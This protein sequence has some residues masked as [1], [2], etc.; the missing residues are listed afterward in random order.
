MGFRQGH[1][2]YRLPGKHR[3]IARRAEVV[4]LALGM[5]LDQRLGHVAGG[6]NPVIALRWNLKTIQL[7]DDIL[8]GARCISDQN[9]DATFFPVLGERMRC[10]FVAFEPIVNYAPDIAEPNRIVS[11]QDFHQTYAAALRSLAAFMPAFILTRRGGAK[12]WPATRR[13]ICEAVAAR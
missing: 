9:D 11:R 8:R 3:E 12:K 6:Y 13:A 10:G 5:I 4:N 2:F 1:F 7:P